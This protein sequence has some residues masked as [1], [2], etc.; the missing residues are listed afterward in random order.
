M[1]Y[2]PDPCHHRQCRLP[3]I[4][5]RTDF[6]LISEPLALSHLGAPAPLPLKYY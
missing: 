2:D 3:D 5:K 1:Y 6:P 4:W